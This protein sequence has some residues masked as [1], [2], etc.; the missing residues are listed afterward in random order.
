MRRGWRRERVRGRRQPASGMVG[1]EAEFIR[2]QTFVYRRT[3]RP[4]VTATKMIKGVPGTVATGSHPSAAIAVNDV[5]SPS[6]EIAIN[7]PHVDASINGALIV[8]STGAT[9][10]NAAAILFSAHNA[11]KTSAKTGI[12]IFAAAVATVR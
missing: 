2:Q 11:M 8:P 12:G 4:A 10:G 6:A 1:D 5:P 3:I 7:S 9:V